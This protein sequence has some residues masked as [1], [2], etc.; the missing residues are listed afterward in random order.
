MIGVTGVVLA[1]GDSS[2]FPVDKGLISVGGE[3]I[4][5]RTLGLFREM[6][7][8]VIVSTNR[9]EHYFLTGARLIGDVFP[10]KGPMGGIFSA[11]LNA[12]ADRIFVAACDMPFLNPALISHLVR[13][14]P[15]ADVVVC[16]FGGSVHPLFGVYGRSVLGSLE[17]HLRKGLTGLRRFVADCGALVIGEEEVKKMDPEG[18][19]FVNINTVGDFNKFI[20]GRI[21]LG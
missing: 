13:A 20:G 4:I 12:A 15:R 18:A 2:R 21:C 10:A 6:F 7:T 19:S 5:D 1:G 9:P 17:D 14:A 3:R 16:S 11:L 8:E